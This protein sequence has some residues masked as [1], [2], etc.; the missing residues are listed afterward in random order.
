M[1]SINTSNNA[2]TVWSKTLW[3]V[4]FLSLAFQVEAQVVKGKVVDKATQ[5]PIVGATVMAANQQT[6]TITDIDGHFSLE[7]VP[8]PAR[9]VVSYIGY[10]TQEVTVKDEEVT[11]Q[12]S[13]EASNLDEVVVVGYGT[14][15][16]TQL[17]GAVTKVSAEVFSTTTTPTLDAALSGSVAGLNVTASSGQPVPLRASASVVATQ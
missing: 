9:I 17:T 2:E 1:K 11:V 10:Q 13:E 7:G 12:L 4:S 14:Q 6:G 16:R 15:R 8:Q 5:E 3:A